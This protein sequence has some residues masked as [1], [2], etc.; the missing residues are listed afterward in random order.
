MSDKPSRVSLL[1]PPPLPEKGSFKIEKRDDS[2]M[3]ATPTK[4]GKLASLP[5]HVYEPYTKRWLSLNK[6]DTDN[7]SVI[8]KLLTPS[9][10]LKHLSLKPGSSTT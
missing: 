7:I 4:L 6:M 2:V 5:S 10:T 9:D 8:S 1:P 3:V